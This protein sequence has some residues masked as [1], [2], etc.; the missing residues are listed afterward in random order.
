[1]TNV[2]D[3]ATNPH[4]VDAM[5]KLG[6]SSAPVVVDGT[7]SWSRFRPDKIKALATARATPLATPTAEQE[8]NSWE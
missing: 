8:A 4:A 5:K 2:V 1:L 3:L 7:T 6:Y